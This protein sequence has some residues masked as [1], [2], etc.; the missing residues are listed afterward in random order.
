[1]LVDAKHLDYSNSQSFLQTMSKHPSDGCKDCT[2]GHAWIL[3]EGFDIN[4]E[5]ILVEG[6]HSGE[7]GI[8]EPTYFEGVM[9]YVAQND[10]D[11][12]RYLWKERSD[13]FW[14]SGS[15]GHR[16]S[17][18]ARIGITKEQFNEIMMFIDEERYPYSRYDLANRQ[19]STLVL[20][21][22]A[23]AGVTLE[24]EVFIPVTQYGRAGGETLKLWTDPKYST[25]TL[26]SPDVLEKSLMTLVKNGQAEKALDW[27]QR[28]GDTNLTSETALQKIKRFPLRY[29]RHLSTF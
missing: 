24:A 3:L 14:Q 7:L 18:A 25:I 16:P 1:M 20:Q 28:I 2:V 15:G 29:L 17:F 12:V 22:A 23:L 19:C 6:G 4:G 13:G 11:P 10:P 5:R 8:N 27:Y 9:E 26:A 21:V